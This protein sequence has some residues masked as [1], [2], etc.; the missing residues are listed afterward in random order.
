MLRYRRKNTVKFFFTVYRQKRY[1]QKGKTV[2]RQKGTVM[3]GYR[4]V[5]ARQKY[6]YRT[7]P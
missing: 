5:Q 2:Y 3:L 6:R 7:P 1:G 4:P